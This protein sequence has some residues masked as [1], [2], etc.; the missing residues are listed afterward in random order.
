MKFLLLYTC[1]SLSLS[2]CV[3]LFPYAEQIP[4]NRLISMYV[5]SDESCEW[6]VRVTL[7]VFDSV[8]VEIGEP[9]AWNWMGSWMPIGPLGVGN[10]KDISCAAWTLIGSSARLRCHIGTETVPGLLLF[11][12]SHGFNAST[13]AS[14]WHWQ[15]DNAHGYLGNTRSSS[16]AFAPRLTCVT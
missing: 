8:P 11:I 2:L 9:D 6:W 5:E 7:V 3:W 12:P 10:D 4:C 15:R 13:L 14:S 16:K 1:Y